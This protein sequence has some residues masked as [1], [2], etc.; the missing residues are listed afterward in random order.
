MAK[1]FDADIDF[2]D[3][4]NYPE[5]ILSKGITLGSSLQDIYD[6]Y[7][8]ADTIYM[9]YDNSY[10]YLYYYIDE[11]GFDEL[12]LEVSFEDG[13]QRIEYNNWNWDKD[14]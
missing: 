3:T 6:A 12:V 7:G 2:C 11:Y 8:D 1:D 14:N 10:V 9:G 4:D 5:M 13:L